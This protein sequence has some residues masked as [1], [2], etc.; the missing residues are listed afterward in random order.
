M[1]MKENEHKRRTKHIQLSRIRHL[2]ASAVVQQLTT[3]TRRDIC[4]RER[5][6]IGVVRFR[7]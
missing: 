6:A 1:K 2:P 5:A 3:L 4:P 7:E